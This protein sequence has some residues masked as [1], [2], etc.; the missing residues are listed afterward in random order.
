M[1]LPT[2]LRIACLTLALASVL[3]MRADASLQVGL[4]LDD[5]KDEWAL[6]LAD[7][8]SS[9]VNT[10]TTSSSSSSGPEE[11]PEPQVE[12]RAKLSH[13]NLPASSTSGSGNVG[14]DGGGAE[15]PAVGSVVSST[16]G[17]TLTRRVYDRG[18]WIPDE[19]IFF[20]LKVPRLQTA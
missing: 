1:N 15:A 17:Q 16:A 20:L 5:S 12:I 4:D 2:Q 14:P 13:S 10:T 11:R 19:P 7:E 3:A 18:Q 8:L 6:A 9:Q